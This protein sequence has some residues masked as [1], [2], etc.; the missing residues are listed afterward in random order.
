VSSAE[1][2]ASIRWC[3]LEIRIGLPEVPQHRLR[4]AF[5]APSRAPRH[6]DLHAVRERYEPFSWEERTGRRKHHGVGAR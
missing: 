6:T 4:I 2:D 1:S 5:K 3:P